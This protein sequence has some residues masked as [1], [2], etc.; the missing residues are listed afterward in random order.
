M[1]VT[2][3]PPKGV[4]GLSGAKVTLAKDKNDSKLEIK[5]DKNTPPGD[6]TV[7]VRAKAKF[8][9]VNVESTETFVVKVAKAEDA[10]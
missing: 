1:E 6:H 4:A 3:E 10:K 2:V 8:N 5:T 9:N 7:T